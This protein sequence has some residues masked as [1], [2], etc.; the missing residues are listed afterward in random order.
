MEARDFE[1]DGDICGRP[2]LRR[3]EE[4][5]GRVGWLVSARKP[6]EGK[7]MLNVDASFEED[8][9]T[10]GTGVVITDCGGRFVAATLEIPSPRGGCF[11]GRSLR[12]T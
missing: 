6:P 7:L 5:G 4:G 3:E 8:S 1:C 11:N 10:A 12:I 9:G 2:A